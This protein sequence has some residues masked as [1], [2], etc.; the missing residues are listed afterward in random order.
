MALDKASYFN[1]TDI[2]ELDVEVT[3]SRHQKVLTDM[4]LGK[5]LEKA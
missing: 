3:K 2:K 1:S 4:V 5:A